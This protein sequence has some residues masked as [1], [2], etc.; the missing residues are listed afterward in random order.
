VA[1]CSEMT[2]LN[3]GSGS[4]SGHTYK[5]NS[6]TS[7]KYYSFCP[8]NFYRFANEVRAKGAGIGWKFCQIFCTHTVQHWR[9]MQTPIDIA[10]D[11]AHKGRHHASHRKKSQTRRMATT[12]GSSSDASLTWETSMHPISQIDAQ[13]LRLYA[14]ALKQ[15][16]GP[17]KGSCNTI[18]ESPKRW[19]YLAAVEK[20]ISSR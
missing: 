12:S 20:T 13:D 9:S 19:Y 3:L 7:G 1:K 14:L 2:G 18:A 17:P 4:L 11:K 8:Y 16:K 15:S 10:A 5:C 6:R